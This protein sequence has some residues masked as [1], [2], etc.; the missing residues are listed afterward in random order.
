KH[1]TIA[2]YDDRDALKRFAR[3]CD[4]VTYEFENIPAEAIEDIARHAPVYPG[5]DVLKLSQHRLREKETLNRLGIGTAPFAPVKT[6]EDL[7]AAIQKLGT[8]AVLK[9]ATMGYD[10]KG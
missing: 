7:K 4:V 6:K 9:T 3:D 1:A 5:P 2:S 10:G 8:P